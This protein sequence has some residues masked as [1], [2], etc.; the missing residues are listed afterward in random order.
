MTTT[1]TPLPPLAEVLLDQRHY[2]DS[3]AARV[4]YRHSAD[5]AARYDAELARLREDRAKLRNRAGQALCMIADL[6][7]E[8]FRKECMARLSKDS[9]ALIENAAT[10]IMQLAETI[11]EATP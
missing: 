11:Q 1:P 6:E 4:A 8:E 5:L 10:L 3:F 7:D 9:K 2:C